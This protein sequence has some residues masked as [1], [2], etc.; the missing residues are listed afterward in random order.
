MEFIFTDL[1]IVGFIGIALAYDA[2]ALY[3]GGVENT[4]SVR[5]IRWSK[6][7]PILPFMMGILMGHFFWQL[8][9]CG[10]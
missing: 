8:D 1:F 6:L 3:K 4:I 9:L 7:Y 10:K 5:I 2:Y